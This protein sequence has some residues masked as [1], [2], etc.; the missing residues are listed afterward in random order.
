MYRDIPEDLRALIEPLAAEHEL[1]LVDAVL[2]RGSGPGRLTVVVDTPSGDGRVPVDR[3]AEL[4]RELSSHLDA[5][6]AFDARYTLEVTSPGLDRVLTRE[7]DFEL[8]CGSEIKVETRAPVDG[9][10]RFRGKL[11]DFQD[12]NA[13]VVVDGSERVIPFSEVARAKRIYEFSR[14][15]FAKP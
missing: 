12:G 8:A 15:D 7:K 14:E 6:D 4:S 5:S 1:E 10:R 9:A 2:Q 13:R 3:C 11:V